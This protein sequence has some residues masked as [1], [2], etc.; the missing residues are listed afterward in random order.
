LTVEYKKAG[1]HALMLHIFNPPDHSASAK[2]PAVVFFFGGGW[3]NGSWTQFRNHSAHLA[4][5]G[6]VAIAADYR[7]KSKHQ[8]TPF[9]SVADAKDAVKWIRQNAGKLG[10]DSKRIAAGGGSAGGHLAAAASVFGSG[11]EVP[12][13]L[14]LFNPALDL[15][16][17]TKI[18]ER[19]KEISPLHHLKKGG[20]PAIVFHGTADV[21]V[22]FSEATQFCAEKKRLGTRCD[23]VPAEGEAHGFF[24]Y[25]RAGNVWYTKTLQ[26]TDAFLVSLGYLPAK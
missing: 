9:E 3:T 2:R 15:A 6:M 12:D 22:P 1:D 21:T 4:A 24:N 19:A 11:D 18:G 17:I 10:V 23:L 25:G 7:I 14:V 8:S 5:R 13:A 16:R 26:A 20:P